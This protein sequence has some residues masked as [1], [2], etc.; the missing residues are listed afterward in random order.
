LLC[1][2]KVPRRGAWP[3]VDVPDITPTPTTAV[4]RKKL[5]FLIADDFPTHR[6]DVSVLFGKELP[7]HGITCDIVAQCQSGRSPSQETWPPGRPLL[8]GRSGRRIRDQLAALAHDLHSL[9]S[10]TAADYDGI[11]VRDKV[12]AGI[13]GLV[14][15]RQL[16]LPFFFWMSYPMSEGFID[17]SRREGL[18]LGVMRWAF[19]S[20][21]AYL[22]RYLLYRYLLPRCDHIFAQSAHMVEML[23]AKKISRNLLTAVP[24]GVDLEQLADIAELPTSITNQLA[25]KR[26]IVYQ[27]SLDRVRRIDLL[28]EALRKARMTIPQACLLLIGDTAMP[29]D[30]QWLQAKA[31]ELGVNEA[32]IW[33]GWVP[34]A[35]VWALLRRADVGVSLIP[36]GELYDCSSPTKVVEY[37]ALGL[38]VVANDL[39]DQQTLLTESGGG[40]CVTSAIDDFSDAIIRVLTEPGRANEMKIAGP[41]YVHDRRSYRAIALRVA[42]VYEARLRI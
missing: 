13:A 26:I 12:F 33:T 41:R 21:K 4:T 8:C 29:S 31:R 39:P 24:M 10:A 18:S 35:T 22:G 27:G 2:T 40:I 6:P 19:V 9:W 30:R 32:V 11:Q 34:T 38:P 16:K 28:L 20:V 15:A 7:R 14:R 25:H 5:L 17:L 3:F 42:A 1:T 23:V 37:L 36:R